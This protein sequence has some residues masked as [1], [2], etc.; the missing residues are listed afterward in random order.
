MTRLLS[1]LLLPL[2][3]L[4]RAPMA[5]EEAGAPVLQVTFEET[6]A[7]PGQPLSLRLT[8]LVP[9][10]M[11]APPV[12]PSLEAPNLLVRLPER[13]T[14]PTS[15]RVGGETW[16]GVTRHYRVSPMVPGGFTIPPQ[17]VVV[18]YADPDGNAPV[19]TVLTTGPIAFTGILPDGTEHLD[20][21]IA[22]TSLQLTQEVTGTPDDMAPGDS[23]TRRIVAGIGGTSPMFLP[24]LLPAGTLDGLAAYP[25]EPLIEEHEERGLLGGTRTEVVTYVAAHGSDNAVPPITLQWYNIGSGQVETASVDGFDIRVTGTAA[26]TGIPPTWRLLLPWIAGALGVGVCAALVL[27]RTA[28]AFRHWLQVRRA[29]R[30]GSERHAFAMLSRAIRQRDIAALYP[31][32]DAW[33]ARVPGY[34]PMRHA[35]V[36]QALLH[37]GSA[38]YGIRQQHDAKA[39]DALAEAIHAARRASRTRGPNAGALPLL[40]P[41]GK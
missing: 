15:G 9:T 13:A 24:A 37:L 25:D 31:A 12:W 11:P 7:I 33:S 27:H 19:R 17:D 40:N 29:V 22:A 28:P 32:V 5:Q 3:L 16:S 41:D 34:D 4:A 8:V 21:F 30:L 36:Q 23:V 10:Y 38:R 18:T 20:P 26:G 6:E 39:W 1:C 35:D 2:L 14:G